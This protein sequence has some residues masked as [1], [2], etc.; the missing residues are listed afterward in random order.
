MKKIN[1]NRHEPLRYEPNSL[2]FHKTRA[3]N[4]VSPRFKTHVVTNDNGVTIQT[5]DNFYHKNNLRR[6][7]TD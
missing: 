5:P 2:A 4:K 3:R 1:E 6:L 7:L